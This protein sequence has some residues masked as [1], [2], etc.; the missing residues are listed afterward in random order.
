MDKGITAQKS[1]IKTDKYNMNIKIQSL[2]DKIIQKN[3]RE[4]QDI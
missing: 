2:M 4:I 1:T 3:Q